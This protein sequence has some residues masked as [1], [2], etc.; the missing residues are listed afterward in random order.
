MY[1]FS[2]RTHW[3]LGSVAHKQVSYVISKELPEL[4]GDVICEDRL[5]SIARHWR[6]ELERRRLSGALTRSVSESRVNTVKEPHTLL[7]FVYLRSASTLSLS[8]RVP[9]TI[10]DLV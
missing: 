10:E 2:A 8:A 7:S 5:L 4:C 9:I 1:G 3:A 6:S